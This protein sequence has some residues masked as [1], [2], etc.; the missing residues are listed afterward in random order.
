MKIEHR[1]MRVGGKST[2]RSVALLSSDEYDALSEIPTERFTKSLR[3][4]KGLM[5]TTVDGTTFA[6]RAACCRG[7]YVLF[8]KNTKAYERTDVGWART[9]NGALQKWPKDEL[10]NPVDFVYAQAGFCHSDDRPCI[11]SHA[12]CSGRGRLW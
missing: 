2:T 7:W 6:L 8:K 10:G 5:R 3:Y 12:F 11:Q 9:K 1:T 4:D